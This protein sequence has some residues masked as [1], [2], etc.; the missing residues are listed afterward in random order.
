MPAIARK[1]QEPP[2]RPVSGQ[3]GSTSSRTPS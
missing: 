2:R 3:M 1:A